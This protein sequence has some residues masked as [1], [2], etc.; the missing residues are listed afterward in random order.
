[1][2]R[3][4]RFEGFLM[5]A[6]ANSDDPA[7]YPQADWLRKCAAAMANIDAAHIAKSQPNKQTISTAIKQ[8]EI[9]A[10]ELLLKQS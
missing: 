6:S 4:E 1:M 5:A 2:R 7:H 3:P 9:A 8:T 10:I